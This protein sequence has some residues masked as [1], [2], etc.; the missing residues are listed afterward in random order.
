MKNRPATAVVLALAVVFAATSAGCAATPTASVASP[1]SS[2]DAITP[3]ASP[4]P[5]ASAPA[6]D[7]PVVVEE[8]G[9]GEQDAAVDVEVAGPTQVAFRRITI[10]PG[11]GTGKHCHD[12]QLI[13]V[14]EQG[15]LTHYAPVYPGGVH[16]YQTG[17]SIVEGPHYV[18]EGKNEGDSDVV[19]LVTYV[20]PEGDPLAETDLTKC[21]PESAPE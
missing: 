6:T 11:A 17:D 2:A 12:G 20:I 15:A 16:V 21:D 3:A 19:L 13:A 18:H 8:L 9:K 10:H 7:A 4:T 5:T 1:S 14:V